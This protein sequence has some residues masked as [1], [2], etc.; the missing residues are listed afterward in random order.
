VPTRPSSNPHVSI[1]REAALM[2]NVR[3]VG[4][5]SIGREKREDP[6]TRGFG[7]PW[8]HQRGVQYLRS[9][10]TASAVGEV[11]P[12]QMSVIA[13]KL[14]SAARNC[15]HA[16]ST[17]SAWSW[18]IKAPLVPRSPSILLKC[19]IMHNSEERPLVDAPYLSYPPGLGF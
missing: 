17:I 6:E 5:R 13:S 9:S 1:P 16:R 8:P 7:A 15:T 2:W 18:V 4:H 3:C 12:N 10:A 19:I 11:G 14:T